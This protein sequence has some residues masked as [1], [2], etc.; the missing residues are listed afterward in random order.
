[1][2]TLK[3]DSKDSIP[4]KRYRQWRMYILPCLVGVVAGYFFSGIVNPKQE[5]LQTLIDTP[6][7][8]SLRADVIVNIDQQIVDRGVRY[9]PIFLNNLRGKNCNIVELDLFLTTNG[10]DRINLRKISEENG[11][12]IEYSYYPK[13][14]NM[15]VGLIQLGYS[16]WL[17]FSVDG[18]LSDA[19]LSVNK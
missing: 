17:G 18:I 10:F 9:A 7:Q 4:G 19:R 3:P 2:N 12:T 14:V 15:L 5:L 13:N 8:K 16:F 11:Y 6:C 1:V